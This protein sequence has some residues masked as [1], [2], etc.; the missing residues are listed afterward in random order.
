[1]ATRHIAFLLAALLI[2]REASACSV[3]VQLTLDFAE[4][5]SELDVTQI[6][7]LANWLDK[8]R[9]WYPY[10]GADVEGVAVDDVPDGRDLA[11]RRAEV[12]ANALRSLAGTI[13]TRTSAHVYASSDVRSRGNYAAIQLNPTSIPDCTPRPI[14]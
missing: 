2:G 12:S 4:G 10:D 3:S 13:L 8:V 6:V 11:R 1:M 5:S 7:R 14:Q 9:G